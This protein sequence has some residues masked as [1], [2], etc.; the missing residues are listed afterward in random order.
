MIA[1]VNIAQQFH[2]RADQAFQHE[3]AGGRR[4]QAGMMMAACK[5]SASSR[6]DNLA[7]H[8]AVSQ[9]GIADEG[10]LC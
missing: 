9:D 6:E 7:F 5:D 1:L 2:L 3:V 8:V 10:C 4:E